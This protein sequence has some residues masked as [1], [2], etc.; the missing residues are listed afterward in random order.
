LH[1]RANDGTDCDT[2]FIANF[3]YGRANDGTDCDTNDCDTNF[4][5]NFVTYS[6]QL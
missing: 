5:A 4:I 1:G 6:L 2:N 3:T